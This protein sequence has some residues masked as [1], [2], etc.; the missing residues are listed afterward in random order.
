MCGDF[1]GM[2]DGYRDFGYCLTKDQFDSL[3]F[4]ECMRVMKTFGS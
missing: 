2:Y 4:G 3:T 1:H